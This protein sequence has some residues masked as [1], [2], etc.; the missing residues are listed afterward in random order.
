MI[1]AVNRGSL[2]PE[3]SN[4]HV[5]KSSSQVSGMEPINPSDID[6]MSEYAPGLRKETTQM[7]MAEPDIQRVATGSQETDTDIKRMPT[8]FAFS[9]IGQPIQ[10]VSMAAPVIANN[11][12]YA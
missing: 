8:D 10:Q 6:G 9:E 11:Q 4:T 1:A 2:R 3:R 7:M 5:G 12:M